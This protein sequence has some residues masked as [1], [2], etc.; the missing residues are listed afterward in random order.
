MLMILVGVSGAVLGLPLI[1]SLMTLQRQA[2]SFFENVA[3]FTSEFACYFNEG[4]SGFIQ[5]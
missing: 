1:I 5:G 3:E 4:K 2:V